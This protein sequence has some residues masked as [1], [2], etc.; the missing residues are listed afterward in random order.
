M[1]KKVL[2]RDVLCSHAS[3]LHLNLKV[4][5]VFQNAVAFF[6]ENGWFGLSTEG[7]GTE[8]CLIDPPES[9]PRLDLWL[10]SC[11]LGTKEKLALLQ[12]AFC[13]DLPAFMNRWSVFVSGQTP[14]NAHLVCLDFLLSVLSGDPEVFTEDLVSDILSKA[15]E[16]LS[17]AALEVLLDFFES[18]AEADPGV[19]FR[20]LRRVTH[21]TD[22]WP[23]STFSRMAELVLSQAAVSEGR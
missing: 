13:S 8:I 21:T 16:V 18:Q 6:E 23:L 3:A 19:S 12:D 7:K 9:F 1:S 2:L 10:K 14:G 4:S 15:E 11:G 17:S 5:K 20:I 22:A